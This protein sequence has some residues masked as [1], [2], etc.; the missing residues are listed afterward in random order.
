MAPEKDNSFQPNP[1]PRITPTENI[2]KSAEFLRSPEGQSEAVSETNIPEIAKP[3]VDKPAV[4]DE[5]VFNQA[6]SL[7]T[8][9]TLSTNTA[10]TSLIA[11]PVSR[12]FSLA[13]GGQ[14]PCATVVELNEIR[15]SA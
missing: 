7:I 3:E 15:K 13:E 9:E 1:T 6:D 14:S 11:D 2:P 12:Y 10:Q 5:T 8:P 4:I